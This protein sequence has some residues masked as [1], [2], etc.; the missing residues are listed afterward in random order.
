MSIPAAKMRQTR[1]FCIIE[2][3]YAVEKITDGLLELM[4]EKPFEEITVSDIVRR[5][6]VGR[7]SFYRHFD[8]KEAV[9]RH[10]LSRLLKEWGREFEAIGKPEE[11]GP[12]LLRHFYGHRNF[13][14]LLYHCGMSHYLLEAIRGAMELDSKSEQEAYPLSWFAG[15]LYGLVDEWMRRGMVTPPDELGAISRE[16]SG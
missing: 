11:L 13:Y 3:G 9:V 15:G 10:H 6:E 7:A 14:L 8:S 5:A 12:S 1:G 4:G 16:S 2:T